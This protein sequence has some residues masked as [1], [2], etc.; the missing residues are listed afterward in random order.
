MRFYVLL[1]AY[2]RTSVQRQISTKY[3][4]LWLTNVQQEGSAVS[5]SAASK[6]YKCFYGYSSPHSN[7]AFCSSKKRHF[8]CDNQNVK[9]VSSVNSSNFPDVSNKHVCDVAFSHVKNI[10]FLNNF[11][12][13]DNLNVKFGHNPLYIELY[14][15]EEIKR[16]WN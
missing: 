11:S 15:P 13:G 4:C 6:K 5:I 9:V 1:Q 10:I 14:K 7:W 3:T 8:D 16:S 12:S 2:R